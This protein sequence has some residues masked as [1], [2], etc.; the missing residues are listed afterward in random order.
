MHDST[1]SRRAPGPRATPRAA[2]CASITLALVLTAC[3]GGSQA[4]TPEPVA[5]AA[6]A[7]T[8]DAAFF[9]SLLAHARIAGW[10]TLAIGERVGRFALAL[11]GAPYLDGTLEGPGDEVCRV[12]ASGYDCVTFMETC[13]A[14]ARLTSPARR[15]Q[16]QPGYPELI[17]AVTATRYRGGGVEGYTSRLHYT[18]EWILVNAARGVIEDVTAALGGAPASPGVRFMSANPERYLALREH[19]ER[20]EEIRA[21]E[22]RLNRDTVHVV[23]KHAV[24]DIAPHLRT[25]DLIAIATSIAGLDYA[26]TGL[27]HRDAAGV[28][29][30]LHASSVK[31]RVVLDVALHEYLAAGPRSQTGI[32]VLRPLEPR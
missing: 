13:L 15:G 8:P 14:L 25:G 9:D 32:S 18:A 2:A 16:A 1:Q 24:A 23:P 28:A 10:D 6:A 21:I 5:T 3:T 30:F 19:P 22:A 26:H 31:R 17:E 20:V 29:R 11:E 4:R 7:M 27:I 12:T